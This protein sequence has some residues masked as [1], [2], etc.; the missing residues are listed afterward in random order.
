MF[1]EKIFLTTKTERTQRLPVFSTKLI[2]FTLC[3][4]VFVVPMLSFAQSM[5]KK[6]WEKRENQADIYYPHNAHLKVMEK[7]GDPCMICHP[8]SGNKVKDL[9]RV[10]K[11]NVIANEPLLA[12]CHSCH[13]EEL[14]AV[15]E[16]GVCH[17]DKRKIWPPE[18]NYD[19]KNRHGEDARLD[20]AGCAKCHLSPSFCT[21]CHFRR[22]RY[23]RKEHSLGYRG[24]HGIDA[25][26]SP[27]ECGKCH[28][29]WF[30][31]DCHRKM[32]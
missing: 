25:R 29:T 16:C 22:D 3:L 23:G 18:H 4:C 27:G 15:S 31:N 28:N 6:W 5:E 10:E 13:V 17:R 8:F 7:M 26:I 11:L 1:K 30:C 9:K 21:D 24:S 14:S 12:I 19:Y 32:K 2:S 20:S